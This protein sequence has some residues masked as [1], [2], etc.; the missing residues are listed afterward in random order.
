MRKGAFV[1]QSLDDVEKMFFVQLGH[2]MVILIIICSL[3][4]SASV[5]FKRALIVPFV[6]KDEGIICKQPQQFVC[7]HFGEFLSLKSP[8]W[9]LIFCYC[10][11]S[12]YILKSQVIPE[13]L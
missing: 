2:S 1:S 9:T 13:E 11:I 3:Y 12:V 7:M 5:C 10:F 4:R 8:C 6:L